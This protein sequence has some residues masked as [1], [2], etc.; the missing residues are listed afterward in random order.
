VDW[1]ADA[2]SLWLGGFMSRG[3]WGVRSGLVNVDLGGHV[4]TAIEGRS[5]VILGGT[6]SPDGHTLALGANTFSSNVW[7]LETP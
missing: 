2:K 4:T 1:A 6:P 3:S 7:L 5:P